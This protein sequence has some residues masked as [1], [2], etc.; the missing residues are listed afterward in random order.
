MYKADFVHFVGFIITLVQ[1]KLYSYVRNGIC[2]QCIRNVWRNYFNIDV[3]VL[4]VK[5]NLL[6]YCVVCG[7]SSTESRG[8]GRVWQAGR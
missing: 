5:V 1:H 6:W 2:F 8:R 4:S 7:G 3:P